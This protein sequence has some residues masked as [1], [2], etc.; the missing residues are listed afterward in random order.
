[1]TRSGQLVIITIAL[2]F[3]VFAAFR[4]PLLRVG[5]ELLTEEQENPEENTTI[6]SFRIPKAAVQ[7]A[8]PSIR[9]SILALDPQALILDPLE[10]TDIILQGDTLAEVPV[11]DSA[12][13]ELTPRTLDSP[14]LRLL[15]AGKESEGTPGNPASIDGES[16]YLRSVMNLS[17]EQGQDLLSLFPP[18]PY[19]ENQP[20]LHGRAVPEGYDQPRTH[21]RAVTEG[22]DQPRVTSLY[23]YTHSIESEL[24]QDILTKMLLALPLAVLGGLLVTRRKRILAALGA[25]LVMP[26]AWTLGIMQLMNLELN[27]VTATVPFFS[28]AITGPFLLHRLRAWG[29]VRRTLRTRALSLDTLGILLSGFTTGTA[30]LLLILS[31]NTLLERLGILMAISSALSILGTTLVFPAILNT[32]P[33]PAQGLRPAIL[34][35]PTD[36]YEPSRPGRA[37]ALSGIRRG[38]CYAGM[39]GGVFIIAYL[40]ALGLEPQIITNAIFTRNS[41][42]HKYFLEN[43]RSG[44]S[45][46]EIVLT[47]DTK[48]EGGILSP[49]FLQSFETLTK[50]LEANPG[51][52]HSDSLI[53]LLAWITGRYRG[54]EDRLPQSME[55]AGENLELAASND[56]GALLQRYTDPQY[57]L[58][59][60]YLTP[61]QEAGT[62]HALDNL[63][64]DILAAYQAAGLETE[65]PPQFE[66]MLPSEPAPDAWASSTQRVRPAPE[67]VVRVSGYFYELRRYQSAVI[68]T[69]LMG[70]PLLIALMIM[71]LALITRSARGG[72][73]PGISVLVS[74][75]SYTLV[76]LVSGRGFSL[77]DCAFLSLLVGVSNDD[78]IFMVL[79]LK[80]PDSDHRV[81][82][83]I[84]QTT[85]IFSL[86]L[87]PLAFSSIIPLSWAAITGIIA[88]WAATTVTVYIL[89]RIF[90]IVESPKVG[91]Q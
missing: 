56:A 81:V 54:I 82:T 63:H 80:H 72:I 91:L 17:P 61:T 15:F 58:L 33:S 9:K 73:L 55:E 78:A 86:L 35:W 7:E 10:F 57:S 48:T 75:L 29:L 53:P 30:M 38:L 66:P 42:V 6:V 23:H 21:G 52:S 34:P 16:V 62:Y 40:P 24:K 43:Q 79:A 20:R 71:L 39:A 77:I 89:P 60:L 3:S 25:A 14:F 45:N 22:Y 8:A 50:T 32:I 64:Q 37:T 11:W 59:R 28:L 85:L 51:I 83:P 13:G 49:Q 76:S 68:Q 88:L 84:L 4:I 90:S 41:P 5:T 1:M 18:E 87:L 19:Q 70:I 47:V 36:G 65:H 31:G 44:L 69:F 74:V 27:A 12:A 26:A 67:S 46:G 2:A